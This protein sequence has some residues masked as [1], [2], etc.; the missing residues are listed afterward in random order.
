MDAREA[1]HAAALALVVGGEWTAAGD[2]LARHSAEWPR[3]V[4]A[5]QVGHLIDFCRADA[6]ELRDRV[7]RTL[8]AWPAD[9][10]GRSAVL[11][12]YAFGLEE[13]GDYARAEAAGREALDGEPLD[14]WAHHAVAHVMEM[15]GRAEDGL[16]W[17]AAR[18]PFWADD[19]AYLQVHNWWH[20]AL[21]HLELG[22][23]AAALALHD[24]PFAAARGGLAVNLIDASALLWRVE[25][26]GGDVGVRWD[27]LA[28]AWDVHADGRTYPFNDFHAAMAYLG[29]GRGG[30]PTWRG[31]SPSF[32]RPDMPQRRRAGRGVWRCRWSRVSPPFAPATS[33]GRRSCCFR[34]DGSLGPSGAAM[35]SAT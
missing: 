20:R 26:S 25:L 16:G 13:A 30:T 22:Q 24:G 28:S 33:R 27:E 11:G 23:H 17:M 32:A 6:R 21:Y 3:D 34:R 4:V 2:A 8:P 29:A 35:R 12:M 9:M 19:A 10:P 1:S 18:E 31:S 5:L 15:Q 14:G 7:A